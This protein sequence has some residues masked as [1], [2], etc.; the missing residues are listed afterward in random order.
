MGVPCRSRRGCVVVVLVVHACKG[1]S[2]NQKKLTQQH[3][4]Q[5]DLTA[6]Q[7]L[8]TVCISSDVYALFF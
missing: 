1:K 6:Q 8:G 4:H 2:M 7:E 5:P 3:D